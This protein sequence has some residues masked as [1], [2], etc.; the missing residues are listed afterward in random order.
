V[1][2]DFTAGARWM[3]IRCIKYAGAQIPFVNAKVLYE[4]PF[5]DSADPTTQRPLQWYLH[6]PVRGGATLGLH[7]FNLLDQD[8]PFPYNTDLTP[9]YYPAVSIANLF[10]AACGLLGLAMAGPAAARRPRVGALYLLVIVA[11]VFEIAVHVPYAS[12][13]RWGVPTLL[14]LYGS[15]VW[16]LFYRLPRMRFRHVAA[17]LGSA[18]VMTAAGS[19]LSHWVRRQAPSIRAAERAATIA[20][21]GRR[22]LP[23]IVAHVTRGMPFISG[24]LRQ[25][26]LLGAGVGP[27]GQASLFI[28]SRG[29]IFS[30]AIHPVTLSKNTKYMVEF[31]ARAPAGS[32]AELSVDL[33]AGANYDHVAQDAIFGPVSLE[34]TNY[35]ATWNSG[36]DAPPNASLRFVTVSHTP[37]EIRNIR[38]HRLD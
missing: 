18:A 37:I 30:A 1:A 36:G 16:V 22:R 26:S 4:N 31:E 32:V 12:E 14:L 35:S 9:F 23:D 2:F 10:M 33:Y 27:E 24:D 29:D 25:W 6:N 3:G 11:L 34:W 21:D 28:A 15:A 5:S 19:I 38:F 8:M 13:V 17:I 20:R 7:A